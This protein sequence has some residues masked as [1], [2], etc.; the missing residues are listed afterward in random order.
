MFTNLPESIDHSKIR[1]LFFGYEEANEDD[2]L[3]D[4]VCFCELSS[5]ADIL[6]NKK[7][8]ILGNKG[9]GKTALFRLIKENRLELK[10]KEC[11]K[12]FIIPIEE[13]YDFSL[14]GER[15]FKSIKIDGENTIKYRSLWEIYT[16]YRILNKLFTSY[17]SNEIGKE[18]K[19][20]WESYKIVYGEKEHY[21]LLS[22]FNAQ[23]RKYSIEIDTLKGVVKPQIETESKE[24][25]KKDIS[26]EEDRIELNITEIKN[27]VNTFLAEKNNAIVIMYDKLD[28]FVTRQDYDIQKGIIS[29]LVAC[30]R[31]YSVLSNI[32]MKIFLRYDLFHKVDYTSIGYDKIISRV[33]EL[34]WNAYDI[35]EFIAKRIVYNMFKIFGLRELRYKIDNKEIYIND[36]KIEYIEKNDLNWVEKILQKIFRNSSNRPMLRK[37]HLFNDDLNKSIIMTIMKENIVHYDKNGVLKDISLFDFL[38]THFLLNDEYST[39]RVMIIFFETLFSVMREFYKQNPIK[40]VKMDVKGCFPLIT[41]D[42]FCEA[43]EIFQGKMN[44]IIEKTDRRQEELFKKFIEKK[45]YKFQFEFK[46]IFFMLGRKNSNEIKKFIVFMEHIGYLKCLSRELTSYEKRQ[47]GLPIMFRRVNRKSC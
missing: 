27:M 29:A 18:L 31:S 39:P 1:E 42:M 30:E 20:Y 24:T 12:I 10:V 9:T 23:K 32:R 6:S 34:Q 2:L 35:R 43:Y 11:K 37:K 44:K 46:D 28:D 4:P 14:I 41:E 19:G 5:V 7:T 16:L 36:K 21:S 3:E 25:V 40:E 8:Y 26:A 45:G 33:T 47:Y 15:I 13:E 22:F 17:D 38:E